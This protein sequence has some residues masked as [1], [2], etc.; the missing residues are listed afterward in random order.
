MQ[1]S[2]S[3]TNCLFKLCVV[4]PIL[5]MQDS[6]VAL[7]TQTHLLKPARILTLAFPELFPQP[8]EM[9]RMSRIPQGDW[10]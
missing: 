6:V 1:V 3:F 7:H 10:N 2:D 8:F 5:D 4:L 9:M